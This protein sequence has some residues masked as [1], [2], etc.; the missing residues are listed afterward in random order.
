MENL[1][2]ILKLYNNTTA[3]YASG[4]SAEDSMK[5]QFLN[6]VI[7]NEGTAQIKAT[8]DYN[9]IDISYSNVLHGQ[10]SVIVDSMVAT[11]IAQVN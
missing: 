10:D 1:S 4:G 3:V 11:G 6:S 5:V 9:R 8:G 2:R 7:F